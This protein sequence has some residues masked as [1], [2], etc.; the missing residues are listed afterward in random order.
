MTDDYER[1]HKRDWVQW[2]GRILKTDS[3]NLMKLSKI[4]IRKGKIQKHNRNSVLRFALLS[5][6]HTLEKYEDKEIKEQRTAELK[7][8]ANQ[9]Q[10]VEDRRMS[11]LEK[12]R[13]EKLATIQA[14]NEA[15]IQRQQQRIQAIEED[16][17][18]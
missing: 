10:A 2:C 7:A 13:E 4:L 1:Y 16:V 15:F 12:E 14:E 9:Q 3:K 17:H 8:L 6:L 5:L 18:V 11:I